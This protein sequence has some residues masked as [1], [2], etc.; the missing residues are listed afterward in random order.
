MKIL[1]LLIMFC[2]IACDCNTCNWDKVGDL[3]IAMVI[4]GLG[5]TVYIIQQ[6]QIVNKDY[7]SGCVTCDW[8]TSTRY[9][10]NY[11]LKRAKL[12]YNYLLREKKRNSYRKVKVI[13]G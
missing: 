9:N 1:I 5:D 6:F 10:G 2:F 7:Y 4:D 13:K 3:R 11:T 12:I 8:G